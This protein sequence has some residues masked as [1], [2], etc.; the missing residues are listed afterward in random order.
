MSNPRDLLSQG[1]RRLQKAPDAAKDPAV[2][3]LDARQKASGSTS[4]LESEEAGKPASTT[5]SQKS[6]RKD[7]SKAAGKDGTPTNRDDSEKAFFSASGK[8]ASRSS[9]GLPPRRRG[10]PAGPTRV[11]LTVRVLV[12]TDA[13]VTEISE[14]TGAGPQEITDAAIAHYAAALR[15]S[16]KLPKK[17]R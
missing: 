15:R 17:A 11:M 1:A 13:L 10:R 5:D 3:E 8:A 14:A 6:S 7:S 4:T 12:E 2:V 9:L 16:G